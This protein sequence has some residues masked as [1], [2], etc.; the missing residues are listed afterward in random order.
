MTP[1]IPSVQALELHQK[2][3]Q[4]KMAQTTIPAD[5]ENAVSLR[6]LLLTLDKSSYQPIISKK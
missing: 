3:T 5:S 6:L 2:S 4:D 1:T